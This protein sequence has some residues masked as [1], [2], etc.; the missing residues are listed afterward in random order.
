MFNAIIIGIGS[1]ATVIFWLLDCISM[2]HD[3][4]GITSLLQKPEDWQKVID[5]L[6][7]GWSFSLTCTVAYIAIITILQTLKR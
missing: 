1:A 6:N 4:L 7:A 2:S 3:V 5:T